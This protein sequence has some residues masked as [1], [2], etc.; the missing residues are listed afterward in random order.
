MWLTIFAEHGILAFV[1]WVGL[2]VQL[3][4]M[5]RRTMKFAVTHKSEWLK[6]YGRM[7]TATLIAF[8]VSGSFLDIS[9]FE[10]YYFLV[11]AIVALQQ[12]LHAESILQKVSG[13]DAPQG[14]GLVY[15]ERGHS[16]HHA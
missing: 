13:N 14:Q 6:F 7:F 15:A 5:L 10:L 12:Q 16:P 2:L 3:F 11:V 4:L 1:A 9:Y 8:C